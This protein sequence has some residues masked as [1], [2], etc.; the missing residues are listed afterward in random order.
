MSYIN[1]FASISALGSN[2]DEITYNLS[3]PNQILH[4]KRNDL[5]LNQNEVNFG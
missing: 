3:H 2:S 4:T 5:L 1:E